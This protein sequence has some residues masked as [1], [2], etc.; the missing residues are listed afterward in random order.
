MKEILTALFVRKRHAITFFLFVVI[1][2]MSLAYVLPPEYEAE[3]KIIV[4]TGREKKPFIPSEK[5]S[6]TGFMQ[7]SMED[8][9]SEV[10]ILLSQ[11]VVAAV[12][13]ANHLDAD[14]PPPASQLTKF[15]VYHVRKGIKHFLLTIGM[16]SYVPPAD[17]PS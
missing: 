12:V 9:G 6:R 10:E 5:N 8:V 15:I 13:D 16:V 3:G 2:A 17:R 7:V 11:P 1:G 14:H 4:T